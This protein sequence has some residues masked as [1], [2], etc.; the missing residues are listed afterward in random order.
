VQQDDGLAG[1]DIDHQRQGDDQGQE[2]HAIDGS[3]RPGTAVPPTLFLADMCDGGLVLHGWRDG[4][5]AYLSPSDAIPLR[6]ELAA[7]FGST[8]PGASPMSKGDVR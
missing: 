2:Q 3:I 6:R 7:A 4:P 8:E 1:R 5:T